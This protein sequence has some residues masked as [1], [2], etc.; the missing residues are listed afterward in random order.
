MA[1]GPPVQ[2]LQTQQLNLELG[3][4]LSVLAFSLHFHGFRD[5]M[6]SRVGGLSTLR[7][8]SFTPVQA[9]LQLQLSVSIPWD[10]RWSHHHQHFHRPMQRDAL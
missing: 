9:S 1:P 2:A 10:T 3:H 7:H 5:F 6:L 8:S 4:Y